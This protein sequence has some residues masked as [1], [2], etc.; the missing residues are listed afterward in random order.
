MKTLSYLDSL[1][2]RHLPET[3]VIQPRPVSLFEPWSGMA[4]PFLPAVTGEEETAVDPAPSR[5]PTRR[6]VQPWPHAPYAL[7]TAVTPPTPPVPPPAT[8]NQAARLPISGPSTP[9]VP[10]PVQPAHAPTP[11]PATAPLAPANVI[12]LPPQRLAERQPAKEVSP[13]T[14]IREQVTLLKSV[15]E[16]PA[17]TTPTLVEIV[18]EQPVQ[19]SPPATTP[20]AAHE[21]SGRPATS[22]VAIHPDQIKP[23]APATGRPT[24]HQP[25]VTTPPESAPTVQ[26][27][28][29]RIEVRATPP[30]PTKVEKKRPQTPVL[31]L[32]EYLRQR[33][34]GRP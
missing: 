17:E 23:F 29:G 30:T 5:P 19:P 2:A 14:I 34:G 9:D 1:V 24:N 15:T 18:R 32:D 27:T 20:S 13:P 10:Q 31:S 12:P 22:P 21:Q 26:I 11:P 25:P 6:D 4:L 8:A 28:I 33:N 7:D 3:A 16:T